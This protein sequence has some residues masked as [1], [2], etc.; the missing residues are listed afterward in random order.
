M[1]AITYFQHYILQRLSHPRLR[2]TAGIFD[3]VQFITKS[4]VIVGTPSVST[5]GCWNFNF[6]STG[7]GMAGSRHRRILPP[8]AATTFTIIVQ[9]AMRGS[10]PPLGFF[11][12]RCESNTC[13][14]I[15]LVARPSFGPAS[16]HPRCVPRPL[17]TNGV[18]VNRVENGVT[19]RIVGQEW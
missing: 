9:W 3:Q 5:S 11:P 8:K 1:S 13:L 14:P 12:D 10:H 7:K 6:F 4:D 15:N 18:D 16:N 2:D 19:R 17:M